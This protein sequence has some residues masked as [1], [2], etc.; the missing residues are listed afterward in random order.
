[1]NFKVAG[2]TDVGMVRANNEDTF[3]IMEKAGVLVVADGMGGHASGEVA[4]R[5]A[6]DVIQD[7]FSDGDGKKP[8]VGDYC[9]E[10]SEE[11][12]RLGSAIR[13]ANIA[14][15][16]VSES[17]SQ[18]HGMGTTVAAVL[19]NGRKMSIAHVGDSRVYLIR[20][21]DIEQLTDDHSLVSEQ[22][23]KD[24]ISKEE[25]EASGM[26]NILTRA[27]GTMPEVQVDISEMNLMP[28]DMLLLC[29]DGLYTM[30]PD[31]DI[32]SVAISAKEPF[33]A[34]ST[35]IRMANENGGKD[36]V[37]VVTARFFD[38]K[39]Y[40]PLLNFMKRFRR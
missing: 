19:I 11:A 9:D 22:V 5:M 26:R 6:I 8:F 38:R 29:S 17:N 2:E 18:Y 39:W 12:N 27:L 32:L 3:S 13:L 35:L 36:N 33:E 4:S 1:M 20:S 25:A 40:T 24:I 21:G 23:K 28:G 7:Y 30:V 16:D 37:T 31:D 15:H 14:I 34:C 10:Y